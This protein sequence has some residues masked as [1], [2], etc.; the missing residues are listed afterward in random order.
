[1]PKARKARDKP[2]E[3]AVVINA[4]ATA[5]ETVI[6]MPP[7]K[8]TSPGASIGAAIAM[9]T[10]ATIPTIAATVLPIAA[11][12]AMCREWLS[13]LSSHCCYRAAPPPK[14]AFVSFPLR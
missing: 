8:P 5:A 7:K 11:S 3:S 2:M 1:M 10:A 6:P 9:A 4:V 13:L 12:C 14:A